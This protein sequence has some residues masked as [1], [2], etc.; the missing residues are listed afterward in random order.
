MRLLV[1]GAGATGGYFGARLV[2]AGRD[3][4]FLVRPRRA[5]QLTER[6]LEIV[7]P[8]GDVTVRPTLVGA[9]DLAEP[10]DAVL[11]TVKGYG[12]DAALD[13]IAP[14]VGPT[15][16]I[17]PVLNGMR[18]VDRIA[19]RFGRGAAVG[20]LC[21]VVADLDADGRIVQMTGQ[22]ELAYGELDGRSTPRI[23]A[24]H[25]MLSG[26]CFSARLSPSIA[27]EMWDKWLLLVWLGASTCLMRGTIGEI[28]AVPGGSAFLSAVF[29]EA[30]TVI[31]TVGLGP[32][33]AA[34]EEVKA[35]ARSGNRAL[36]SSM[37]RDLGKGGRVEAEEIVGDLVDRAGRAG[38]AT[39]LLAAARINLAVHS[40]RLDG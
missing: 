9:G 28:D 8:H 36:A 32:S 18:H 1:V 15:T 16:A 38:I 40:A 21:K 14:A 4:T 37:Y 22:Q 30:V 34:I 12:L 23:R 13:D 27:A 26:A 24:V 20:C 5:A 31:S 17:L 10:F 11:L 3:V 29:D 7:S 6:G 2:A 39:P 35:L 25:E 33:A 19:E